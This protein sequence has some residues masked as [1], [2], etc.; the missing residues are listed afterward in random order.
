MKPI[1]I[2]CKNH[3]VIDVLSTLDQEKVFN[4]FHTNDLEYLQSILFT[5]EDIVI[6]TSGY[7]ISTITNNKIYDISDIEIGWDTLH[8]F[9]ENKNL[10]DMYDVLTAKQ[11]LRNLKYKNIF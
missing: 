8:L 11:Y 10:L 3:E 1:S 5:Y 2:I 9:Y 6:Y 4:R 7:Y